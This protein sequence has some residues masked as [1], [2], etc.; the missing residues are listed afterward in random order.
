MKNII[1]SLSLN[2]VRYVITALKHVSNQ[3][4]KEIDCTGAPWAYEGQKEIDTLIEQLN[5]A[6]I[7]SER[8]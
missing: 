8:K 6:T 1:I 4:Q 3:Y 2:Q 5:K 7:W